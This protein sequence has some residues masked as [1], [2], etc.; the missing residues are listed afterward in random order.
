[1]PIPIIHCPACGDVP[2]PDAQLPVALPEDCVPD[3]SGNPLNKRA[4]FLNCV[5]PKCGGAAK[6]ET[7][8]MDTFVDS[9]WYY[10]RFASKAG[11]DAMVDAET[12]YWMPV[13]QYIGGI[14]HAILHLLYSRF[15]WKVMRDVGVR[16]AAPL[17]NPLPQAGEGA[18]GALRAD[19]NLD[20][21]FA[22]L[23]TQGMVLNTAFVHE[24]GDGTRKYFWEHEIDIER[25]AHG[26]IQSAKLKDGTPL[27][28][29]L[30]TMSKS[31]NNGVDPQALIDRYGADTAR[32]FIMFAAPPDQSLE[33]SDAGVEGA[34]RFLRRL[35]KLTHDHVQT[36][37]V[38]AASSS[39]GLAAGQGDLRRK[40]HQTIGK[41]AD[42][43]GRRQQFNTAIAAVMELL[44]A[45]DK[46]D[47]RDAT[48]RALAQEVLE[49]AVL[50][51]FPIAPHIGQALYGELRPGADAYRAAFPQADPAAL[52]Q[53]E[54]ELVVQVNGK[55]RGAIRVPVDAD[56]AAIEAA[57]LANPE[58]VRFMDGKTAKKIVIVPGRLVNIVV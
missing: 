45:Y 1:C 35:W 13:D 4:D 54:I 55:L 40:L 36:G 21:P 49:S 18:N 31:K 2:V 52:R 3:G 6:R 5:C 26:R 58:A 32:L 11:K 20:E 29:E 37:I 16:D 10:A 27:R 12:N 57:A 17:P 24:P 34:F 46:T 53:D 39:D 42:D 33:W 47:L 44:N 23:L 15:W 28:V 25:D 50:L 19:K 14:E 43:Y 51:L 8:T 22:N 41:V 48:G 38:A 9:S 56:K 7:D 30:T